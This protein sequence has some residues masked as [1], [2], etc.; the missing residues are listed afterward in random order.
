MSGCHNPQTYKRPDCIACNGGAW[1]NVY[2]PQCICALP[3]MPVTAMSGFEDGQGDRIKFC[4]ACTE[5][6]D[7]CQCVWKAIRELQKLVK[8]IH[9]SY[10][11]A[12]LIFTTT[13]TIETW[14]KGCEAQ[15]NVLMKCNQ[16]LDER[17]KKI[18]EQINAIN[19]Q[20][21]SE[22]HHLRPD[23]QKI[24][25]RVDQLENSEIQHFKNYKK[26]IEELE[27]EINIVRALGSRAD[28][29]KEPH[30]CPVCDGEVDRVDNKGNHFGCESCEKGIVWG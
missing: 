20:K 6:L 29:S 1:H 26:W 28:H 5:T 22:F 15:I 3:Y 24:S 30:K 27:T 25:R 10:V 18:E 2:P 19:K 4:I 7:K 23:I 11:S 21:F 8:E 14:Q 9:V 16:E 13:Q 17:I 12:Q